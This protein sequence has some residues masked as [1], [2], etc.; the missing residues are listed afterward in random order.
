MPLRADRCPFSFLS[1]KDLALKWAGDRLV[2]SWV[3]DLELPSVL[4]DSSRRQ[5]GLK[6]KIP[7]SDAPEEIVI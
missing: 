2:D 3:F 7:P 5:S 6:V 4:F 1:F